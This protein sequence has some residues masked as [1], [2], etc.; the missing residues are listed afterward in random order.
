[1]ND[2]AAYRQYMDKVK[3]EANDFFQTE[4]PKVTPRK[5]YSLRFIFGNGDAGKEYLEYVKKSEDLTSSGKIKKP[6]LVREVKGKE[7]VVIPSNG[8]SIFLY[9]NLCE[10]VGAQSPTSRIRKIAEPNWN[11]PLSE[12]VLDLV[13]SDVKAIR[14]SESS[15]PKQSWP[16]LKVDVLTHPKVLERIDRDPE[17]ALAF[18]YLLWE[19]LQSEL[20]VKLLRGSCTVVPVEGNYIGEFE[21]NPEKILMSELSNQMTK[22]TADPST[23]SISDLLSASSDKRNVDSDSGI[24]SLKLPDGSDVKG[25]KSCGGDVSTKRDEPFYKI[26]ETDTHINIE[27]PC[28]KKVIVMRQRNMPKLT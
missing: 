9:V 1:M 23:T 10:T 11:I 25:T 22:E 15:K 2:P 28:E 6:I 3:Q 16:D 17:F 27:I 13:I 18:E 24:Q 20:K 12:Q 7:P 8:D 4:Y 5:V 14:K 26:V 19:S 21:W